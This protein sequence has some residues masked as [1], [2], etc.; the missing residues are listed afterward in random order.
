[1][2]ERALETRDRSQTLTTDRRTPS[3]A[4]ISWNVVVYD[5]GA[6]NGRPGMAAMAPMDTRPRAFQAMFTSSVGAGEDVHGA[7]QPGHVP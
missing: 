4:L 7:P 3:S 5:P 6:R 1:M 2:S